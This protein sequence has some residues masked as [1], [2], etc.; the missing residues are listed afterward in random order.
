MT[1]SFETLPP[2]PILRKKYIIWW[3]QS[4]SAHK[5]GSSRD[6]YYKNNG[7]ECCNTCFRA[8]QYDRIN[9]NKFSSGYSL[10]D[11]IRVKAKLI[12]EC[13]ECR[14]FG[15][16]SNSPVVDVTLLHLRDDAL[17]NHIVSNNCI[18]SS[19]GKPEI[20][21]REQNTLIDPKLCEH[22]ISCPDHPRA[23]INLLLLQEEDILAEHI[24]K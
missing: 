3:K 14:I 16:L 18:A 11:T 22:C 20:D 19:N 24:G 2:A 9:E 5:K 6:D 13:A 1:S 7:P 17:P 8:I 15:G 10:V 12:F 21:Y 4:S 23:D